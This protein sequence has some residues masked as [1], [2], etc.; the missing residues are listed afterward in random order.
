MVYSWYV[1]QSIKKA[2]A[3]RKYCF[4]VGASQNRIGRAL[5]RTHYLGQRTHC[6]NWKASSKQ[7]NSGAILGYLFGGTVHYSA[8]LWPSIPNYLV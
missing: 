1:T 3:A 8:T 6:G 7:R 4:A 2:D 5:A